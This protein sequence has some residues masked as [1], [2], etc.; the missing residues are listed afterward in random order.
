MAPAPIIPEAAL[1]L[2]YDTAPSFFV[3]YPKGT[4]RAERFEKALQRLAA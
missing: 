2:L 3:S 1:G 4:Q